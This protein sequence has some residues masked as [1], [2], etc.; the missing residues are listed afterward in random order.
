M[1]EADNMEK[2]INRKPR[3]VSVTIFSIIFAFVALL[4]LVVILG[5]NFF[6]GTTELK[7]NEIVT[8]VIFALIGAAISNISTALTSYLSQKVEEN[9]ERNMV[10]EIKSFFTEKS[11]GIKNEVNVALKRSDLV[12]G[13]REDILRLLINHSLLIGEITRISILAYNSTAFSDFFIEHFRNTLLRK[14]EFKCELLEILIHD[15]TKGPN[16]DI[17]KKWHNFYKSKQIKTLKIRRAAER[18]RSFFGM[19]IEFDMHHPIGLIGFYKPQNEDN[20]NE[21]KE[22]TNP[23]GVFSEEGSSV[24]KVLTGYFSYYWGN[25]FPLIDET[26]T[27]QE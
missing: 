12:S 9:R 2:S 13:D 16:D 26:K 23:Y 1:S 10:D 7:N 11:D 18:R 3:Q 17:I 19:V 27:T 22:I 21:V 8:Y 6:S 15:Q 20:N 5:W 24:L 14:K 4:V 25:A